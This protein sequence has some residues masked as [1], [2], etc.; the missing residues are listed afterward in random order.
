MKQFEMKCDEVTGSLLLV[1]KAFLDS[2]L[3]RQN[4][5]LS[6]LE[7]TPDKNQVGDYLTEVEAQKLLGRKATWFWSMRTKGLLPYS[8][9]GN[10]VFY[11]KKDIEKLLGDHRTS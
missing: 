5:I 7:N 3:E 1:P 2:L 9:V 8:K 6:L 10:K 11:S 4:K